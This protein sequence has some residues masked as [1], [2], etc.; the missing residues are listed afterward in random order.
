MRPEQKLRLVRAFQARH[1]VVALTGDGVNDAPALPAAQIGIAFGERG[2]DVAREA[3]SLVIT[4]DSYESIVEGIRQGRRIFANLR[5]AMAYVIAVHVPISGMSLIPVF[6][7]GWPIVLLPIQVAFLELIIDPACSIAFEA[8]PRDPRTMDRQPRPPGEPLFHPQVLGLA[9]AQGFPAL[10][11]VLAVYV[12]SVRS[13]DTPKQGRSETFIALVVGNLG[14]IL[15][16]RSW[17]QSVWEISR[18]RANTPLRWI[19]LL[20]LILL[21]ALITV[22]PLRSIFDIGAVQP[23]GWLVPSASG[24]AAAMAFEAYKLIRHRIHQRSK[25]MLISREPAGAAAPR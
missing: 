18:H 17:E 15:V 21:A 1:A 24:A 23:M 10:I 6:L 20:A 7:V 13:G 16:N 8:E 3:A 22:P 19:V 14:L 4:D 25:A 11:A 2:S 5:K 9:L 12:W